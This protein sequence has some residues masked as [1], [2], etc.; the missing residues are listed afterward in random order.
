[1][2]QGSDSEALFGFG[3]LSSGRW[4]VPLVGAMALG[5]VLLP[6]NGSSAGNSFKPVSIFDFGGVVLEPIVECL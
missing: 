1:M 3:S 6:R 4:R 2:E 5:S